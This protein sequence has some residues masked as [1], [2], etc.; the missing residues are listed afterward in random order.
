MKGRLLRAVALLSLLAAL[1]IGLLSGRSRHTRDNFWW[2]G[3][4]GRRL[5][6]AES[7]NGQLAVRTA[8]PWPVA[9]RRAWTVAPAEDDMYVVT[10]AGLRPLIRL[11]VLNQ[12]PDWRG[13]H[14]HGWES[15][16]WVM[17]LR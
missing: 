9:A 14:T 4:A 15:K 1:G 8:S 11:S 7:V 5:W 6:W 12:P 16:R 13:L 17:R 3:G 10:A 2:C